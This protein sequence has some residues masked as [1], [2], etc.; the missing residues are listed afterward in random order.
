MGKRIYFNNNLNFKQM[1][2]TKK[3]KG[4]KRPKKRKVRVTIV[5]L[6]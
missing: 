4:T 5:R 3:P 2:K 1:A 6:P